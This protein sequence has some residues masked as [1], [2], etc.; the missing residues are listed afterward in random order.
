MTRRTGIPVL[1]GVA[2]AALLAAGVAFSRAVVAYRAGE[3]NG[4]STGEV[5]VGEEVVFSIRT[6]AGGHP[7]LDRARIIAERL[8]T[9]PSADFVPDR[10]A[11]KAVKGDR[12]LY[13]GESL[14]VTVTSSEAAAHAT[15][16]Q[17]LAVVWE[18]SLKRALGLAKPTGAT[19]PTPVPGPAAP[20]GEAASAAP[21]TTTGTEVDWDGAKQ[22]WVPILSIEQQGVR[23]GAAQVA[24]PATQVDQVKGVAQLRL[25]FRGFARVYSYIPVST[26]SLTK[27]D[28]VQGVSV[29][30]VGDLQ[31]VGF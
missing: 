10:V 13:V 31:L 25:D 18:D 2:F 15:T 11:V 5:L 17:A 22:K 1:V 24:G 20:G 4:M 12:A 14:I 3:Y 29:W 8:R 27:L 26:L 19:I 9:V 23:V 6:S 28:R 21:P 30:A 16:P 7:A